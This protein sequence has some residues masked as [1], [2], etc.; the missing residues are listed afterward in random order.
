MREA[1][2]VQPATAADRSP[3]GRPLLIQKVA[4]GLGAAVLAG[5][6]VVAIPAGATTRAAGGEHVLTSVSLGAAISGV[7]GDATETT[8]CGQH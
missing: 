3:A 8:C 6:V 1:H 5:A 4:F 7:S 2:E